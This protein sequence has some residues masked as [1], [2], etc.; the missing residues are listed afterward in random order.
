V[1]ADRGGCVRRGEGSA[2]VEGG[3]EGVGVAESQNLTGVNLAFM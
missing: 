1:R 2:G 3:W